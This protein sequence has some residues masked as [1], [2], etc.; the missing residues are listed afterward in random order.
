[1]E[2]FQ[3]NNTKQFKFNKT[4]I[5]AI[6]ILIAAVA[7]LAY[8]FMR[9]RAMETRINQL[10]V[11]M[12]NIK[13]IT[14]VSLA[15]NLATEAA[16]ANAQSV[17]IFGKMKGIDGQI[18]TLT[19]KTMAVKDRAWVASGQE[20]EYKIIVNSATKINQKDKKIQ[21]ADI[22]AG[23][24]LFVSGNANPFHP[25]EVVAETINILEAAV[26]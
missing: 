3:N 4:I 20:T 9:F 14:Q 5:I 24:S 21:L 15:P 8:D 22:K 2:Q 13:G 12:A 11:E 26:K 18:I 16:A 1:M 19:G 6:I 17:N 7:Y 25:E 10:A 23:A